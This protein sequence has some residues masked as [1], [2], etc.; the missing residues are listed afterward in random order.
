MGSPNSLWSVLLRKAKRWKLFPS[1][2]LASRAE[3]SATFLS[4]RPDGKYF[5]FCEPYSLSLLTTQCCD[6]KAKAASDNMQN[7]CGCFTK[8]KKKFFTKQMVGHTWLVAIIYLCSTGTTVFQQTQ[9]GGDVN[10]HWYHPLSCF[11]RPMKSGLHS[12][13]SNTFLKGYRWPPQTARRL[14]LQYPSLSNFCDRH[15]SSWEVFFLG[16]CHNELCWLSLF[17]WLFHH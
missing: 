9:S 15:N 16:F 5:R 6:C 13:H 7:G 10:T 17:F 11:L 14:F 8:K 2:R 3:E 4:K 12:H 1:I